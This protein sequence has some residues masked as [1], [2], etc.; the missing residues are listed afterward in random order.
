MLLPIAAGS[1]PELLSPPIAEMLPPEGVP[2]APTLEV[3]QQ[4][5]DEV[6]QMRA[7]VTEELERREELGELDQLEYKQH[8][9]PPKGKELKNFCIEVSFEYPGV[10]GSQC[11]GWYNGKVTKVIDEKKN[12]VEIEWN[13]DCLGDGDSRKSRHILS[14]GNWN[15]KKAKKN[16]WRKYYTN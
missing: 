13:E 8:L 10:D 14:P 2:A 6:Q 1:P 9:L 16:G 12:S 11:L 15:P 3:P 7:R 4:S 5:N